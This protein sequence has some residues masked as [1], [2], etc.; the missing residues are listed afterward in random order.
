M[1]PERDHLGVV[2]DTTPNSDKT[3]SAQG[4]VPSEKAT[5]SAARPGAFVVDGKGARHDAS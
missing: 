5:P 2:S 4:R 1:S 3:P